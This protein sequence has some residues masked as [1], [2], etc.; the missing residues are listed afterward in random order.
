MGNN[1]S[2]LLHHDN[3][4]AHIHLVFRDHFVKKLDPYRSRTTMGLLVIPKT[5]KT[6]PGDAFGIE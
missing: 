1:S 5:Q 2:W 4:V 6:C 3:I